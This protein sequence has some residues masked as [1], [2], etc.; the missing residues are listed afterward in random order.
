MNGGMKS[1]VEWL[2]LWKLMWNND[3]NNNNLI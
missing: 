1:C 3:W 2:A